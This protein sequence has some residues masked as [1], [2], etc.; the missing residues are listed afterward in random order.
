ME[1]H[2]EEAIT[3]TDEKHEQKPTMPRGGRE[4]QREER[5]E[6]GPARERSRQREAGRSREET[7]SL[8]R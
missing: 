5:R 8:E 4:S 3:M 7:G 6:E 1:P 2:F